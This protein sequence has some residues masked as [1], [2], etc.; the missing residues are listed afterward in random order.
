[1]INLFAVAVRARLTATQLKT[2]FFAYPTGAS[3]LQY[4]LK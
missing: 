3:D 1:V 2:T 4:M